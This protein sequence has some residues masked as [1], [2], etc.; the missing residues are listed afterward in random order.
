TFEITCKRHES[1]SVS[2]STN[3]NPLMRLYGPDL[4]KVKEHIQRRLH[5]QGGAH[6]LKGPD[7]RPTVGVQLARHHV[8]KTEKLALEGGKG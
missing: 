2:L 6:Y 1:C 5:L 3:G 7:E 4:V 8:S